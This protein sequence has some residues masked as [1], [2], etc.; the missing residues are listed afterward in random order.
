M[1]FDLYGVQAKSEN[2]EY[3]RNN[4]WWWRPLASYVL[5]NVALPEE[6]KELWHTNDGHLV[7][8]KTAVEIADTLARLVE[9]GHTARYEKEYQRE[10]DALPLDICGLCAGTGQRNDR[11]VKGTCNACGGA[12]KVKNFATN[13]PFSVDNVREFAAFCRESGGFTIC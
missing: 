7:S 2:G 11:F 8:E 4:V 6:G 3:F 9:E 13:Y 12:G 5:E 1:G 10:L